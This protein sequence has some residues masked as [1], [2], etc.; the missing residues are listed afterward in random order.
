MRCVRRRHCGGCGGPGVARR[1]RRPRRRAGGR[2]RRRGP[3]G[4]G[5]PGVR[6]PRRAARNR[7]SRAGGPPG[8]DRSPRATAPRRDRL[9]RGR[10]RAARVGLRSPD[11]RPVRQLSFHGGHRGARGAAGAGAGGRLRR[12]R[13]RPSRGRRRGAARRRSRR[14]GL[15]AVRPSKRRDRPRAG[16]SRR[17]AARPCLPRAVRGHHARD[18]RG[19]RVV[20][21]AELRRPARHP[22]RAAARLRMPVDDRFPKCACAR[23][24]PPAAARTVAARGSPAAP[25]GGVLPDAARPGGAPVNGAPPGGWLHAPAAGRGSYRD[26]PSRVTCGG[27]QPWGLRCAAAAAAF[28]AAAGQA[29]EGRHGG[30]WRRGHRRGRPRDRLLPTCAVRRRARG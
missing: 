27:P 7:A 12:A 6:P 30:V 1:R 23:L 5:G 20:V 13:A 25:P 16:G 19:G 11:R 9:G 4:A 21:V 17:A 15:A 10:V 22:L 8:N 3:D 26:H 18:H 24:P 29:E 14:H 28:R 2:C